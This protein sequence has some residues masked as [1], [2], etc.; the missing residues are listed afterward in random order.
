MPPAETQEV[1]GI[2]PAG[3]FRVGG[4]DVSGAQIESATVSD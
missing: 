2:F 1:P 4:G 3:D